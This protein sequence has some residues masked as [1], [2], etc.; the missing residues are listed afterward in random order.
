M[1]VRVSSHNA[2]LAWHLGWVGIRPRNTCDGRAWLGLVVRYR[3]TGPVRADGGLR[4]NRKC[5]RQRRFV[6]VRSNPRVSTASGNLIQTSLRIDSYAP[7]LKQSCFKVG[8]SN[9]G[10]TPRMHV[11]SDPVRP[12]LAVAQSVAIHRL[13][14]VLAHLGTVRDHLAPVAALLPLRGEHRRLHAAHAVGVSSSS[15]ASGCS[16]EGPWSIGGA[17]SNHDRIQA[18]WSRRGFRKQVHYRS[19]DRRGRSRR[20]GRCGW[21]TRGKTR[22]CRPSGRGHGSCDTCSRRDRNRY[23]CGCWRG[24]ALGWMAKKAIDSRSAGAAPMGEDADVE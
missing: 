9:T 1:Y 21:W 15:W 14:P 7:G 10:P 18:A 16:C 6:G 13:L 2:Y 20:R 8:R 3:R 5:M 4:P 12:A 22:R 23:R 19:P 24:R 17:R 11:G